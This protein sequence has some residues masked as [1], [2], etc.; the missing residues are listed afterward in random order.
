MSY[1]AQ[2]SGNLVINVL[3]ADQ[4]FINQLPNPQDYVETNSGGIG[5]TFDGTNFIAPKPF[6]SWTLDSNHDWQPPTPKPD[7]NYRWDE[8]QL[9]WVLIQ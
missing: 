2:L 9:K 1:F 7:G 3:V 4:E 6:D 8:A 5:W